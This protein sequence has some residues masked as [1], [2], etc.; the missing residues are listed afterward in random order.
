[1][2]VAVVVAAVRAPLSTEAPHLKVGHMMR[3]TTVAASR[4]TTK[5]RSES[6][7]S[8]LESRRDR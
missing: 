3:P 8:V 5:F 6:P 1:V 4:M 7:V 2:G